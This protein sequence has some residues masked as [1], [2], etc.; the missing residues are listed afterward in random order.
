MS[1]TFS[2]QQC[3]VT[4]LGEPSCDVLIHNVVNAGQDILQ[5]WCEDDIMWYLWHFKLAHSGKFFQIVLT[6]LRSNIVS[7]FNSR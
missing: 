3:E 7:L 6:G 1:L 2:I 4:S 5:Y